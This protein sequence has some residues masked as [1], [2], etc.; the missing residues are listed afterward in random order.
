MNTLPTESE[1]LSEVKVCPCKRTF[2]DMG[3][4][5]VIFLQVT[6]ICSSRNR[7]FTSAISLRLDPLSSFGRGV[8]TLTTPSL[9]VKLIRAQGV[10]Y[11]NTAFFA[12]GG[13]F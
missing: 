1:S 11:G 8:C 13:S 3:T 6:A 7:P 12:R 5:A 2:A 10:Y 4:T 9:N